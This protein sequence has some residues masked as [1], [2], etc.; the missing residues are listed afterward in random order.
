M[1]MNR[2]LVILAGLILVSA[3]GSSR[4]LGKQAKDLKMETVS[5]VPEALYDINSP[6]TLVYFFEPSCGYCQQE[7]PKVYKVFQQFKNYG[8]A[9]FCVYCQDDKTEWLEYL[10][11]NQ[12]TDWINVWDPNDDNGF[13][14]AYNIY[15]VPQLYLLDENKK[16][17]AHDLDSVSLT[18]I[19][20]KLIN[21]SK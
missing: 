7:T 3:C 21:F 17:I 15:S 1:V 8:L 6:Y 19:L 2:L 11:T 4:Q 18:R 5:G 16:I 9:V 14:K 10:S 12:F 20:N 13:R